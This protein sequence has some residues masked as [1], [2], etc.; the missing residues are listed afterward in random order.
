MDAM[1]FLFDNSMRRLISGKWLNWVLVAMNGEKML[2][3]SEFKGE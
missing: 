1:L 3:K 2:D